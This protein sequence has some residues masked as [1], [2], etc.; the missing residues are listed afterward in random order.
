MMARRKGGKGKEGR[1]DG[2]VEKGGRGR[3]NEI[4]RE[5]KIE[6]CR[7]EKLGEKKRGKGEGEGN[8]TEKGRR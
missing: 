3:K 7:E 4:V 8:E 6:L 2:K 1:E 5:K